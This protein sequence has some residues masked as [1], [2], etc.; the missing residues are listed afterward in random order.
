MKVIFSTFLVFLYQIN[1]SSCLS[2]V[3]PIKATRVI[4]FTTSEGTYMNVD[5]SPDGNMLVFDLLGD[6][7]S[8][9]AAGGQAKQI[10]RG[11]ALHLRPIWS[12]DGKKIA[13]I[14]DISGSFHLNVTDLR[15]RFHKVLGDENQDLYYGQDAI[16]IPG[17][18]FISI[19]NMNYSL[20]ETR[21]RSGGFIKHLV[22]FSQ[23]GRIGYGLD[24]GKIF[25]YDLLTKE[26]E[27]VGSVT[28][29]G[30]LSPNA[31]WWCYILDSNGRKSLIG[32]DLKNKTTKILVNNMR[33]NG[34]QYTSF[35][36]KEHFSFSPDSRLIYIAY[37][38]KIHR[39]DI[40]SA[41]NSVVPFLAKIHSDLGPF[42]YNQ[43]RISDDPVRIRYMRS[44]S[45]RPDGKQMAFSA[46]GKLYAIE[47]PSGHPRVLAPQSTLQFQPAY[48]PD[49]HWIAY[50]SWSDTSG[51]AVWRVPVSGG[52]PEQ[53]SR[54]PGEFQRPVWSPDS[55]M[56][57]VIRGTSKLG[58]RD[59]PGKGNLEIIGLE[60]KSIR[61]VADSVP[62]WNNLQFSPDGTRIVFTPKHLRVW[63]ND[64]LYPQLISASLNESDQQV[65]ALGNELTYYQ[66]KIIS[67]DGR[68]I[69]YSADEDLYITPIS[70][71]LT[72]AVLSDESGM[73]QSIRFAKGVDPYWDKGG[74]ILSWTYGSHFY[75]INPDKIIAAPSAMPENAEDAIHLKN[76]FRSVIVNPDQTTN[77]SLAVPSFYSHKMLAI[78]DVRIIT[79]HLNK[80]I[81]HGTILMKDGRIVAVGTATSVVVPPRT[82]IMQLSGTTVMPRDRLDVHLHMRVPSN[83]FPQQS[84]MFLVNLAYGVTTA[85]DPSLSF[86]S[87]G[88][89]EML[90]TG[91]MIG[92]RLFTVGRAVR[93]PD[94]VVKFD[95]FSDAQRVVGMRSEM[96]ATVVKQYL[97]PT[98]IQRQ[99]L[100][101]A[102]REARLNMTNEG[103]F[104]PILQLG[105]IKDGSTGVEH[106]PV[107][108]DV[109]SDIVKFI[110]ASRVYF[111]P[112]L[113]VAY[114]VE[115][116]KEYFKFKYWRR[117]DAKM[118][119]FTFSDS[120]VHR[121][122]TNGSEPLELI[123]QSTTKDSIR[124]RFFGPR[125]NRH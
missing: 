10:T 84:W 123:R 93:I 1:L 26:K 122:T 58:D 40:D 110:G 13:Y 65:L 28:H 89:S 50:V 72:P 79:M 31:R 52:K 37:G 5:V 81:E 9:P 108:G 24:S 121:P 3:L 124:S 69:V 32:E 16:W 106:N 77:L 8:I 7:Y 34:F 107:W 113:Q 41:R 87:F 75:R 76:N 60:D 2:Q 44:I 59:D 102:C 61:T 68:F 109:Y 118:A 91:Q 66:Q 67:P 42:D 98:R 11:L 92:P 90:R 64:S 14:S 19:G 80:V 85:R 54:V 49:G 33:E 56:I 12:P 71:L 30:M 55:K 6:L 36:P 101:M 119:Y 21:G 97:L 43:F 38:G 18:T 4:S 70:T 39:I 73:L 105:M 27:A 63:N 47:L 62:L 15:G 104:D 20:A 117:P 82:Q 103:A 35:V 48:S 86:D 25:K 100:L 23:D 46:L 99:W 111:T 116:S 17:S 22:R 125:D 45:V 120:S 96:G 83:V 57:A 95:N 94:G 53:V 51:G 112:T 29:M 74:K 78:K 88:Y 114:G 115:M